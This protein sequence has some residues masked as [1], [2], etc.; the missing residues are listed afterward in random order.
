MPITNLALNAA[1]PERYR[2]ESLDDLQDT[3]IEETRNSYR[4][5]P[6]WRSAKEAI[7]TSYGRSN[8]FRLDVRF[9]GEVYT[10]EGA[11]VGFF[12][13][14]VSQGR[15]RGDTFL[16]FR[17]ERNAN[18]TSRE[19]KTY[20]VV[21]GGCQTAE[22]RLDSWS[23]GAM[24]LIVLY[25]SGNKGNAQEPITPPSFAS[26]KISSPEDMSSV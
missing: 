7:A 18:T 16:H 12:S 10:A 21:N 25:D 9:G 8:V 4:W 24:L 19:V 17:T 1:I 22:E 6:P 5:V 14:S 13:A 11:V 2:Y 20:N 23:I 26:S 15:D 3:L